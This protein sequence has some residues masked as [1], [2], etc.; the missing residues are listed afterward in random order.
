M[1][2]NENQDSGT[3]TRTKVWNTATFRTYGNNTRRCRPSSS[4]PSLPLGCGCARRRRLEAPARPPCTAA[5]SPVPAAA[6]I[7][8]VPWLALCGRRLLRLQRPAAPRPRSRQR[9]PWLGTHVAR[10]AGGPSL[11]P[12]RRGRLPRPCASMRLHGGGCT[13][14]RGLM[15]PAPWPASP[16]ASGMVPMTT[17]PCCSAPGGLRPLRPTTRGPAPATAGCSL[18]ARGWQPPCPVGRWPCAA[19]TSAAAEADQLRENYNY[20]SRN[21]TLR[22]Y[23]ILNIDFVKTTF[24]TLALCYT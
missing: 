16:C 6:G 24:E 23:R 9:P 13:R 22:Y 15:P 8:R 5:R 2:K 21:N 7:L 3:R 17:R 18:G 1:L 10:A 19:P 4:S 12:L 20:R 11:R 14:L